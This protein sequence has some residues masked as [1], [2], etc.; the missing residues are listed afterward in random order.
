MLLI[1]VVALVESASMEKRRGAPTA[2]SHWLPIMFGPEGPGCTYRSA[3]TG[4]QVQ[5]Q[6]VCVGVAAKIDRVNWRLIRWVVACIAIAAEI[7]GFVV[8]RR[9]ARDD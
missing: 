7:A 3:L 6:H 1:W 9:S 5:H 4:D 2:T 8:W